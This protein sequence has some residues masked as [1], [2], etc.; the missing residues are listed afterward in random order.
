[1]ATKP[2]YEELSQ[3]VKLLE[4]EALAHKSAAKALLRLEKAVAQS[5]DG[6]AMA[7]LEGKIQFVNAAWAQ[8][9][10]YTLEELIGRHLSTFHTVEQ[11]QEEVIPFNQR[12]MEVGANQS[13][14]GHVRSD[15][16]TFPTWMS[17]TL[18]K[19][20]EENI[21][22]LLGIA[23][24]ITDQKNVEKKMIENVVF[25]ESVFNSIQDGI[26]VL[27]RDCNIVR[28]NK[29]MAQM[30]SRQ[31]PLIG[32]KCYSVFQQRQS[33]C[34]W[35]PSI[36]TMETGE[37]HAEIVPY[38]TE[39]C[40]T[41]WIDLTTFPLKDASG[42]VVGI[43]EYVK[44]ITAH[45][46]AEEAFW[47]SEEKYRELANSLPQ[48]VFE[49]DE[50][51]QVTFANHDAF[52]VFGYDQAEFDKGLNALDM[53]I[54]QDREGALEN[55]QRVLNGEILGGI[56]YTALRKDGS[57]FPAI[58]HSNSIIL[59][60][61]PVGL[62][63]I[64]IDL[65]EQKR[66]EKSLRESEFRFRSLFDLSPQG[67][68]L[69]EMD[70]GAL[71]NVNA[72]FCEITKY[73]REELI[74][75]STAE[76]GF[77]S[78]SDRDHFIK[79]LQT[80]GEVRGLKMDFKAKD[81]SV[82]KALMFARPVNIAGKS[83]IITVIHDLTEQKRLE[84]QLRQAQRMEAIGTLAGGIA[85][86]FNNILFPIIGYTE[87]LIDNAPEGSKSRDYLEEIFKEAIRARDLIRQILTF[88]RQT[89]QE[90][91]PM[92]VQPVVKEALK[93][94][95]SSIPATIHF[96][97]RIDDAS[98]VIMGDPTKI[99]Q[100][101]MNLCTNAYHAMEETGGDL[102]VSLTEIELGLDDM[103]DGIDLKPGRYIQ[104]T[105]ADT[106]QG[107][108]SEVL[109][110]IF[111]PYFTTK[112]EGKGTGLGLAVVHGIIKEFCGDIRVSSELGKGSV[113]HVY[114]PLI[115]IKDKETEIAPEPVHMG[116]ERVLLVDDEETIVHMAKRMLEWLGYQTTS[117]TSS[118]EAL[119]AFRA[120][121]D[122]F[123]LV[124]TDM[125][126]P[127]MSGEILAEELKKI[128]SDIPVILC[129]GFSEKISKDRATALGIEGFLMKPTVMSDLAKTIREVLD[130]I[131]KD[132]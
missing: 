77:Y 25:F 98:S 86:D 132:E 80:N 37:A 41:G 107:I 30:Y 94:L 66:S 114:L 59:E 29:R 27:D 71:I 123:D 91:K 69:T 101:V 102:E 58:I 63:G 19:D 76:L 74:G 62:R 32:K 113:F 65:S 22:G 24:D 61:K 47:K 100:L 92:R 128:R 40:Q 48:I 117:R 88:S 49:T 90:F 85:H 83:C 70:S 57:T 52:N 130:N 87:M 93:L 28:V 104:L 31:M 81:G 2:T 45:K 39:D 79:A 4:K 110:R 11:M 7:D 111:D 14:I 36:P 8:M 116:S 1:M 18:L 26:S 51:G 54:P 118:I 129:T 78:K 115:E 112:E 64:M 60:N 23:R 53:L 72:K 89:I 131:D 12:M 122:K 10:G 95:R 127:N 84:S 75:C 55:M 103:P 17:A 42:S 20:D 33:P 35:C 73:R 50:N 124:I 119:E 15:G 38:A 6:I 44:D 5:I 99:H 125:T 105:V 126:M 16:T 106:G 9:H 21:A 67:I 56:E 82:I 97:W 46:N 34:P 3:K 109:N 43:I 68:A 13:E 96:N 120:Q 121:P 108:E